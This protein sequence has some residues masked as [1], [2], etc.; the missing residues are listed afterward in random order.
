MNSLKKYQRNEDPFK[1]QK[2]ATNKLD[3]NILKEF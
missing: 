3:G 1:S 2:K